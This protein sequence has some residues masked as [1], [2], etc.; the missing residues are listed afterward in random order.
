VGHD[1]HDGVRLW[2]DRHDEGMSPPPDR[3]P[4]LVDKLAGLLVLAS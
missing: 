1:R 4:D 2:S 3:R